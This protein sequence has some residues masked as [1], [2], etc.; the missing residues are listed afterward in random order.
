MRVINGWHHVDACM[1]HARGDGVECKKILLLLEG[2]DLV[3]GHALK[4][5]LRLVRDDAALLRRLEGAGERL[6]RVRDAVVLEQ[7]AEG[8]RDRAARVGRA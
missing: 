4:E 7:N 3:V 1:C 5:E 2:D 8:R 6:Q